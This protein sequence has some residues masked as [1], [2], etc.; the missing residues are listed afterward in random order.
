MSAW[1]R[2][3]DLPPGSVSV[4]YA[5]PPYVEREGDADAL[6]PVMASLAASGVLA[7]TSFFV[8]EQRARTPVPAAP[9]FDLLDTR[10]YGKTQ[11]SLFRRDAPDASA[12]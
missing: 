6:G 5:D 10:H 7:P 9:G 3:P 1:L 11:V 8:A 12:S 4:V 2:R